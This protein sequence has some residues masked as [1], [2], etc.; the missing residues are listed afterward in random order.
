MCC[1]APDHSRGQRMSVKDREYFY[2]NPNSKKS[3]IR[4][5]TPV[6]QDDVNTDYTKKEKV[7]IRVKRKMTIDSLVCENIQVRYTFEKL[8]GEGAFGKVNIASLKAAPDK[9]Y[10]I[11]SIPRELFE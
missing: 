3:M 4:K 11:K 10:A 5:M 2:T 6:F 1:G 8:I 7:K 9:K